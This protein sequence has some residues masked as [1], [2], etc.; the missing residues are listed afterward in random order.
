MNE[1][2]TSR[3][4]STFSISV[5]SGTKYLFYA[6]P[7]GY[8]NLSS[9]SVGGFESLAAFTPIT[10]IFVNARGYSSS[11]IIYVSNNNFSSSVDNI[12]CK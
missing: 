1:F 4:K 3:E 12:N 11:Y 7:A 6:Y 10:R 2:A 5:S 9:L 8:S